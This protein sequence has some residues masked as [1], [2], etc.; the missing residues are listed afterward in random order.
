MLCYIPV[1]IQGLRL[2]VELTC[3]LLDFIFNLC[4]YVIV[5]KETVYD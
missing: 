4:D 2:L 5:I 3:V 1:I